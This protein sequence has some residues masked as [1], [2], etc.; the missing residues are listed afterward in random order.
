[1]NNLVKFSDGDG[2]GL[3]LETSMVTIEVVENGYVVY[4]T[5]EDGDSKHAFQYKDRAGMM[6]FLHE[7]LGV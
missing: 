4:L 5:D 6:N 1:V 7:V 2:S 3:E